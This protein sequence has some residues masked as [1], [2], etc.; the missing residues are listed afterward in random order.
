MPTAAISESTVGAVTAPDSVAGKSATQ[1]HAPANTT[2]PPILRTAIT[3]ST[4]LT[5]P[6]PAAFMANEPTRRTTPSPATTAGLL[7][8]LIILVKY[9]PNVLAT[10]LSL[11]I[12]DAHMAIVNVAAIGPTPYALFRNV[13]IPPADGKV[14]DSLT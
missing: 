10:R 1:R 11:R 8:R 13:P 6:L 12:I 5:S 7:S 3:F 14:F 2:S 4:V 9:V